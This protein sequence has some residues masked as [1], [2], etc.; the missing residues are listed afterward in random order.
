MAGWSDIWL[1]EGFASYVANDA[2]SAIWP[3]FKMNQVLGSVNS[4]MNTDA[5]PRSRPLHNEV[6]GPSEISGNMG[7][8]AYDKGASV[9]RMLVSFMGEPTFYKGITQ[10][11]TKMYDSVAEQND[12]FEAL[13]GAA[14]EAGLVFPK[15]ILEIMQPWS[16]Q[17]GFPLIRVSLLEE[18]NSVTFSQELWQNFDIRNDSLSATWDVL[19]KYMVQPD[20]SSGQAG[21]IWMLADEQEKNLTIQDSNNLWVIINQDAG[22][23]FRTIYDEELS[24][25]LK[26]QLETDH[27]ALPEVARVRLLDDQLTA[28]FESMKKKK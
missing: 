18:E 28:G 12:L 2:V 22:G 17:K 14:N 11:L 15:S 24:A 8:I 1:N 7:T 16:L 3:E 21:S 25:R 19:I 5:G 10:Y 23:Y 4:A 9:I 20:G 13:D 26:R 27:T 6:Y